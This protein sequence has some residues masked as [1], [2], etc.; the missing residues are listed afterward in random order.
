M[1]NFDLNS[2]QGYICV[3]GRGQLLLALSKYAVSFS[4]L[5]KLY[6]SQNPVN[7]LSPIFC[8]FF[9]QFLDSRL[10]DSWVGVSKIRWEGSKGHPGQPVQCGIRFEDSVDQYRISFTYDSKE[11]A[12][13]LLAGA[14]TNLLEVRDTLWWSR[15]RSCKV[16]WISDLLW[17]QVKAKTYE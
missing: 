13:S 7:F 9:K 12:C 1:I 2:H 15:T 6:T 5:L 4:M 17:F 3:Y 8:R 10:F 11:A 14:G 16:I